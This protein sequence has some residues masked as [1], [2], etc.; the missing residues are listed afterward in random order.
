MENRFQNEK[1]NVELIFGI[2]GGII[3]LPLAILL[4]RCNLFFVFLVGALVIS[5]GMV[6][7]A[8]H[9]FGVQIA[10]SRT[11]VLWTDPFFFLGGVICPGL[12]FVVIAL[13]G[14]HGKRRASSHDS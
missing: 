14:R 2:I 7:R 12:I 3:G 5:V 13:I 6:F 4:A 11:F 10:I 1:M 8:V 9:D